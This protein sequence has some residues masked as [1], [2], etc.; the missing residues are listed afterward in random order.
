MILHR[1]RR[2][3]PLQRLVQHTRTVRIRKSQPE[4]QAPALPGRIIVEPTNACNLSCGYC[5]N[6]DMVRPRTYLPMD[7]FEKLLDEMVALG[8]PRITLHTIG[9]PTLHP[10]IA[11]MLALAVARQ[12]V[13]TMS[14]NGTLLTEELARSLVRAGPHMLHVSVDAADQATLG[15][16]RQGAAL[17]DIITGLRRLRRLRD[18]EGPLRDSPW[19]RVR[20]PTLAVTCVLTP[21]FTRAVERE[22]FRTFSPIVDDIVFHTANNHGDYVHT[23]PWYQRSL[24]PRRWRKGFYKSLRVPCPYPWDTLYLLSDLTVSACRWD[25]DARVPVGRFPETSL[26]ELWHGQAMRSL[27]RAHMQADF[28]DWTLCEDCSGNLYENRYEHFRLTNK[29]KRRNGMVSVR[30]TWQPENPMGVRPGQG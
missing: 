8:I 7:V 9:E 17:D 11:D 6:K 13:V 28:G 23:E 24:L 19:G 5:G 21:N 4:G 12:R 27:R 15:K 20:M 29:L 14:T 18:A 26:P 10:R 25:F 1:L 3:T 2:F 16:T 22:F 30:N